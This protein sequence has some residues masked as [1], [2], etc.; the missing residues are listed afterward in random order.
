MTRPP[1]SH[2]SLRSVA[3]L[4]LLRLTAACVGPYNATGDDLCGCQ[5]DGAP[6][7]F[8]CAGGGNITGVVF[9]SVGTPDGKCGAFARG[10]CDGDPAA[11]MAYVEAT[12]VGKLGCTLTTDIG[13]FNHGDDPCVGVAKV[14]AVQVTCSTPQP[15]LPPGPPGPAPPFPPQ[16]PAPGAQGCG[17]VD[18]G[19]P[20]NL[21]CPGAQLVTKISFASYGVPLD[22]CPTLSRN[23]LC[24]AD[25]S[26]G[27]GA[28][29]SFAVEALCLNKPRCIVPVD[30]M[31]FGSEFPCS[32]PGAKALGVTWACAD[33][34]APEPVPTL[35]QGVGFNVM[36]P[37]SSEAGWTNQT[38][39]GGK[40][41]REVWLELFA[42]SNASFIRFLDFDH[43]DRPATPAFNFSVEQSLPYLELFKALGTEIYWTNFHPNVP[44]S[45]CGN[46]T[47]PCLPLT[48]AQVAWAAERASFL[49]GLVN[50]GFDNLKYYCFANELE[51]VDFGPWATYGTA[52]KQAFA[53]Q[54]SLS[55]VGLVGLDDTYSP[56]LWLAAKHQ[57]VDALSLHSYDNS[58]F[59]QT[60]TPMAVWSKLGALVGRPLPFIF[61]E[62]GG[63]GG[64][65]INPADQAAE[66]EMA[67]LLVSQKAMAAIAAGGYAASYWIFMGPPQW[68]WPGAQ[69]HDCG[70]ISWNRTD[71]RCRPLYYAFS[72]MSRY[73]RGPADAF[74]V[75]DVTD[76]A[77]LP[78][79]CVRQRA[80]GQWSVA[81][82]NLQH[83]ARAA[84]VQ[85]PASAANTTLFVLTYSYGDLAGGKVS[86]CVLPQPA[87]GA[88][89]QL[90]VGADGVLSYSLPALTLAVFTEYL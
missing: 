12:C 77:A 68:S 25:N 41:A 60:A 37:L 56:E 45:S 29:A 27:W 55:K 13:H 61:G 17:V 42:R 19:R 9:A 3:A 14:C 43:D 53:A 21:S 69:D 57:P 20:F 74:A 2:P 83:Q 34:S 72:M 28:N 16:P 67:A 76:P 79:A 23:P 46:Q 52:I 65:F 5:P 47:G 33:A 86:A 40:T 50:L 39:E 87:P 7:V 24:D 80:S 70:L 64:D 15:P 48:P 6:I 90:T 10:S 54:P 58:S 84:A 49:A 11:A 75:T 66:D 85:L 62:F 8:A 22:G 35:W 81:A 44:G 71:I 31:L 36:N 38:Y 59:S 18:A 73:F 88:A 4:L 26:L 82:L 63:P 32:V 78:V 51:N 89:G 30:P 1:R